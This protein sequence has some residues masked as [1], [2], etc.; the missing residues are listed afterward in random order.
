MASIDVQRINDGWRVAGGQVTLDATHPR[1]DQG[2]VHAILTVGN[3][4]AIQH[5]DTV[6]LTSERARTQLLKK[7]AEKGVVLTE[8]P[9]V[10]LDQ[11]CRMPPPPPPHAPEH[12]G[13]DA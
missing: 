9:L 1:C 7:L 12:G 2:V 10:A 3:H 6:N 5:R 13:S 8:E 4:T 11:A